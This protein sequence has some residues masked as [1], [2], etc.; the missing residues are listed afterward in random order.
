MDAKPRLLPRLLAPVRLNVRLQNND[1]LLRQIGRAYILSDT[2]LEAVRNH[3]ENIGDI[4]VLHWHLCGARAPTPLA[5]DDFEEFENYLKETVV[6]GD[7]IDVWPF[8]REPDKTIAS[9]K[10]PDAEGKVPIKVA[11]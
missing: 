11:Y 9:G 5:F 10:Y 8:P 1:W 4:V 3:L 6:E 2:N 7:A